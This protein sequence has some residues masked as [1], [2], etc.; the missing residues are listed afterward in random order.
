MAPKTARRRTSRPRVSREDRSARVQ[1][2]A[3]QI[4]EFSDSIDPDQQAE[5]EARFD[6]YSPRNA[7]LIVMQMPEATV[8]RGFNAWNAE[9]RKVRK[10]EHGIQVLAPAGQCD[11]ETSDKPAADTPQGGQGEAK[12]VRRLFRLAYVFDISQTEPL[13]SGE[14]APDRRDALHVAS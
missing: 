5:Y 10:G 13:E 12:Q 9:G 1:A 2:L 14:A 4:K 8:V 11:V 7:L 3:D 6:H